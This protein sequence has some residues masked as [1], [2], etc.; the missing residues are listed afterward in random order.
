[1]NLYT[2]ASTGC[3]LSSILV[4]TWCHHGHYHEQFMSTLSTKLYIVCEFETIVPIRPAQINLRSQ[5]SFIFYAVGF[6]HK[7]N[8]TIVYRLNTIKNNFAYLD[9][10]DALILLSII[11][12][13]IIY[14]EFFIILFFVCTDKFC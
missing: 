5:F 4:P 6:G 1:M 10:C 2:Y 14:S 13:A 8:I 7:F 12:L 9:S 3:Q 11:Y